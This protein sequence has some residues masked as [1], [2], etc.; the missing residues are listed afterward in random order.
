MIR[1]YIFDISVCPYIQKRGITFLIKKH[2]ENEGAH[3]EEKCYVAV[4]SVIK[5]YFLRFL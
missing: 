2:A 3:F 4:W 1:L 5:K